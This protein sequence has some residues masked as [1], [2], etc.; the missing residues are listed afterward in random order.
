MHLHTTRASVLVATLLFCFA[1]A[2]ATT[3]EPG[4]GGSGGSIGSGG[5]SG[6]GG[7]GTGGASVPTYTKDVQ[8]IFKAKCSPCH[9]GETVAHQDIATKYADVNKDVESFDFDVCWKD[10]EQTMPK[11]VG[12]CALL[13]IQSGRMPI[14]SGCGSPMPLKPDACL[15]DAQKATVAAWVAAGM[16]Q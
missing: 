3:A 11:K 13:L 9:A 5:A 2:P 6:D 1:C 4:D 7:G 8:P 16:P 14:E 15:S 12:E 10:T